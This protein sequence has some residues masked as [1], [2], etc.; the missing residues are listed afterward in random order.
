VPFLEQAKQI[1]STAAPAYEALVLQALDQAELR[2]RPL[3]VEIARKGQPP[4]TLELDVMADAVKIDGVRINATAA[5]ELEIAERLQATLLT[6]FLSDW[7]YRTAGRHVDPQPRP[8][9][10]SVGAMIAH[11]ADVDLEAAGALDIADPGKDW[12][13]TSK[14]IATYG[15][16]ASQS[17]SAGAGVPVHPAAALGGLYVVQQPYTGHKLRHSDYSQTV[18]LVKRACHYD[19]QVADLVELYQSG[20]GTGG[21]VVDMMRPNGIPPAPASARVGAVGVGL[22]ALGLAVWALLR[23]RH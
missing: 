1:G 6:P 10:S 13:G 7:I 5:L 21:A 16:H 19:G 15:W 20:I 4:G 14:G 9:T 18:R 23:S 3:A 2:W 11:S 8:I 12:V 22:L 17:W